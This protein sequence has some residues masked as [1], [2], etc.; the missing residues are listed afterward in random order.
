VFEPQT[1]GFP[2]LSLNHSGVTESAYRVTSQRPIAAWQFGPYESNEIFSAD[3]SLL[4][5]VHSYGTS[6]VGVTQRGMLRRP[7][8]ND[9][10]GT[11]TIVATGSG[12]TTVT[13]TPTASVR[14][15]AGVPV[16][17]AGTTLMFLLDQFEV[18]NLEGVGGAD[19]TGTRMNGTQPFAVFGGHEGA[20]VSHLD[21]PNCC[22]DHL[23]EQLTA[24]SVWGTSFAIGRT[25]PRQP[26]TPDMVRIVAGTN[27]T[28]VTFDP[29]GPLCPVLQAGSH[30]DAFVSG[31]VRIT[32][33]EPAL[34]AHY[35][36]SNSGSDQTTGDPAMTIVP[37]VDR[38]ARRY[39][40]AAH[41]GYTQNWA[42]IV[43][44]AAGAVTLDGTDLA[45]S[46]EPFGADGYRAARIGLPAGP[47]TIECP[48]TCFVEV[49]GYGAYISY[50]YAGGMTFDDP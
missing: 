14:A 40:V 47:H 31:D 21:P 46:L 7:D 38:F 24:T 35:L 5:P 26:V 22:I 39:V 41:P 1:F 25:S 29:P 27:D 32:T 12:T 23:Q 11:L 4:H 2:D 33:N 44:P 8:S 37:P 50:L 34:V 3:A 49:Y 13:V 17:P 28:Q 6:Y 15:G 36:T 30:C 48:S 20:Q 19:L 16:F 18:L 42:T 43:A 10:D 45:P 9:L